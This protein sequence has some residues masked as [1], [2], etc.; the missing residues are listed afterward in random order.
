MI[1]L[2][3]EFDIP[4]ILPAAFYTLAVQRWANGSDGGR[5]HLILSPDDL[6][7]LIVGREMLQEHLTA[8]LVNWD[9]HMNTKFFKLCRMCQPE[10]MRSLQELIP[11]PHSPYTSW[12]LHGLDQLSK[13][14]FH[15]CHTCRIPF[16]SAIDQLLA[17]LQDAIPKYFML[18]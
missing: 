14:S 7:R 18:Q 10:L 8:L 6:R 5:S 12:L 3:R 9:P 17:Q 15:V 1:C 11:A 16:S 4:E 13:D 2:A